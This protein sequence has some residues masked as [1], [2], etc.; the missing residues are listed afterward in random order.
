MAPLA[1]RA[2]EA[3]ALA[4]KLL[5]DPQVCAHTIYQEP[6]GAFRGYR[7]GVLPREIS[8]RPIALMV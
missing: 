8:C 4:Q 3:I 2:R 7:C 6:L 5:F 1:Q